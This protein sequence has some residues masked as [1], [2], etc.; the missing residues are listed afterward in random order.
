MPIRRPGRTIFLILAT[1]YSDRGSGPQRLDV[2]VVALMLALVPYKRN[3]I[4]SGG[5]RWFQLRSRI[6]SERMN[7]KAGQRLL[8]A[9]S[10]QEK[11]QESSSYKDSGDGCHNPEGQTPSGDGRC[12]DQLDSRLNRKRGRLIRRDY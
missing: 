12:F 2:K 6:C 9:M 3:R 11:G 7:D 10:L 4:P 5:Q 8:R 1:R